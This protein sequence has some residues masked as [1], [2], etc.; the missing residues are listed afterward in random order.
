VVI[1]Y[2]FICPNLMLCS[3]F[4]LNRRTS[5]IVI[6]WA[7]RCLS[8]ASQLSSPED[9]V[10]AGVQALKAGN[11]ETAQN[12]LNRAL[13]QGIKHPIV[14]HN[15]GVIAQER[16]NAAQAVVWFRK[17]LLLDPNYGP[18]RLLLGSS[19]LSLGK[20]D[21]AVRELQR[22]VRS[23]PSE[24]AAHLQLAKAYEATEKWEL[25]VDELQKLTTMAPDNAEYSYQLGKALT[26]LSGWALQQISRVNPNSARLH[27]ALGQEY[28]IQG[29]YDRAL[30]AYQQ[31][32][33]AD[34]KLPEIHLGM[35][36]ILLEL[37]R[38]DEALAQV[39]LELALV[40]ESK[41]AADAKAKI[42]AEKTATH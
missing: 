21:D 33:A 18:S 20:T 37:K 14:F 6:L 16:R 10:A 25:A 9:V 15:L 31:A 42:E 13:K 8:Q 36:L 40:P 35:A 38:F 34:P 1:E 2:Q 22:A 12:F 4:T 29:K 19:L 39:N 17:S 41:M 28:V 30:A 26:R 32:A 7:G 5:L 23:M 3:R 24:P 27:Q 11:L